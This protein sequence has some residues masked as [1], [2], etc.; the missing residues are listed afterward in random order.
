MEKSLLGFFRQ[1]LVPNYEASWWW[2]S[3]S[4]E[5]KT[6]WATVKALFIKKFADPVS[7]EMVG[8]DDTNEILGLCQKAGQ[9]I[10]EYL[11]EAEHLHRKIKPVLHHTL[12]TEVVQR[13]SDDQKRSNV[14]FALI[15]TEYDFE[16]AVEKV[17]AA[18]RLIGEPDP[19]KP[20]AQKHWPS[21]DPFYSASASGGMGPPGSMAPSPISIIAA[22]GH[23]RR[24]SY[25]RHTQQHAGDQFAR[26]STS[27]GNQ[28]SGGKLFQA[29]F[30][31]YM[32]N[33]MKQQ[34]AQDFRMPAQTLVVT[35]PAFPS[36]GF[37]GNPWVTCFN[38]GQKGHRSTEC[39]GTPLPWED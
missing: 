15:G 17:K 21:T 24:T 28:A 13:L 36:R 16:K 7:T 37:T 34:K 27:D 29:E 1:N 14:S 25:D 9:S 10:K 18:Y 6:N 5:E 19:F 30:N 33:Y 12:P 23:R 35:A 2:G 38:S 22:V 4:K 31:A 11:Q 3:L 39:S 20:K 8:Y 26:L 32:E